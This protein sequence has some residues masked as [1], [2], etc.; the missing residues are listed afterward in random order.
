VPR[1]R[2]RKKEKAAAG[3]AASAVSLDGVRR[4]SNGWVWICN[5]VW[6]CMRRSEQ[7]GWS[8]QGLCWRP[9]PG[10]AVRLHIYVP[11][12]LSVASLTD[13]QQTYFATIAQVM[14]VLMIAF[15]LE[16]R[17]GM[18]F[19]PPET[20]DAAHRVKWLIFGLVVAQLAGFGCAVLALKDD[21][22]TGLTL[23]T[24]LGFLAGLLPVYLG[25]LTRSLSDWRDISDKA[26][27]PGWNQRKRENDGSRN[28]H[29]HRD[30]DEDGD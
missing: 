26:L 19:A 24:V 2:E 13:A 6:F 22:A 29:D 7:G 12:V 11:G 23:V 10:Q 27:G 1:W 9:E 17:V 30:E 21:S 3:G 20:K 8:V 28:E 4:R 15:I 5:G 16:L 25:L 14:P 18:V